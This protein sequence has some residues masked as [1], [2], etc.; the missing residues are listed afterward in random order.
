[1]GVF[2]DEVKVKFCTVLSYFGEDSSSS[3]H[4]FFSTLSKFLKEFALTRGIVERLFKEE[5][6]RAG[7]SSSSSVGG[8]LLDGIFLIPFSSI[9]RMIF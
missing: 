2:L 3:S 4:E 6:K 1:M 9:F 7:F 8:P 5:E